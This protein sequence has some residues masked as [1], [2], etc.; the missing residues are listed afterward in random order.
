MVGANNS[1][2]PAIYYDPCAQILQELADTNA[3]F[4]CGPGEGASG[5]VHVRPPPSFGYGLVDSSGLRQCEGSRGLAPQMK[6]NAN[7]L[8]RGDTACVAAERIHRAYVSNLYH[9]DGWR[10]TAVELNA[11]ATCHSLLIQPH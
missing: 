7:Y 3:W 2:L 11:D 8:R 9:L 4:P 10:F 6:L 1:G 5:C